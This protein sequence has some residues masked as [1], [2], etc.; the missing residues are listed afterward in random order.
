VFTSGGVAFGF[1]AVHARH[2]LRGDAGEHQ[3]RFL[4]NWYPVID[5]RRELGHG[6]AARSGFVL[7]V[8]SGGRAGLRVDELHGLRRID[9]AG[10]APLPAVYRGPERRWI[11]GLESAGDA[12]TVVV[13]IA[14]L[15][16]TFLPRERI[17]A[18]R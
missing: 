18:A 5:L 4:D 3:I 8:E 2:V 6:A 13:R 16:E 12:V 14:E 11:A 9:P 17:G 1:E 10:L 7:L 15:L